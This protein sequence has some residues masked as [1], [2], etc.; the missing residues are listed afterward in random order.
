MDQ[1][2][3][4]VL[5]CD[6]TV[7][8]DACMRVW[9]TRGTT[10]WGLSIERIEPSNDPRM[11][12]RSCWP[13]SIKRTCSNPCINECA[14][15]PL[16]PVI[17]LQKSSSAASVQSIYD[18]TDSES[19]T[20]TNM[21]LHF[22]ILCISTILVELLNKFF[23]KSSQNSNLKILIQFLVTKN[24]LHIF[25]D[26]VIQYGYIILHLLFELLLMVCGRLSSVSSGINLTIRRLLQ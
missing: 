2:L 4:R 11:A 6:W 14:C 15:A 24:E 25:L 16:C 8:V 7:D 12:R 26:Y 1:L 10:M 21:M 22:R 3:W 20:R 9:H 17:W 23:A 19:P 5:D 18:D 13:Q